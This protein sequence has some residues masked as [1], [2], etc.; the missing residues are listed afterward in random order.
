MFSALKKDNQQKGERVRRCIITNVWRRV[1]C[2]RVGSAYVTNLWF[3]RNANGEVYFSNRVPLWD[4]TS[5]AS[6]SVAGHESCS[7][8]PIGLALLEAGALLAYCFS[9]TSISDG[10]FDSVDSLVSL[11][12]PSSFSRKCSADDIGFWSGGSG[13]VVA[14]LASSC[15]I[16]CFCRSCCIR[17]CS[18]VSS[19]NSASESLLMS[20][21]RLVSVVSTF[22]CSWISVR[23]VDGGLK[24]KLP[25]SG[26]TYCWIWCTAHI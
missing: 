5:A 7:S 19:L 11:R 18:A 14:D 20:F 17:L 21:R 26:R 15:S 2:L 1:R 6:S 24:W 4:V 22:N 13:V 12:L 23:A 9:A 3:L 16:D 10:F 25:F 8:V